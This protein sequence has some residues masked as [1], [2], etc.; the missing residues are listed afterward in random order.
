MENNQEKSKKTMEHWK[1][2]F[3]Q[4]LEKSYGKVVSIDGHMERHNEQVKKIYD[5]PTIMPSGAPKI[6]I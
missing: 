2:V 6:N 1:E 5:E 3:R 4:G